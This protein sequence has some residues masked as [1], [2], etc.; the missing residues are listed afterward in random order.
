[1]LII[2]I[3]V[4]WPISCL[5]LLSQQKE[6]ELHLYSQGGVL[7][8]WLSKEVLS[9][10]NCN[11]FEFPLL[12]RCLHHA[13]IQV[14]KMHQLLL[15]GTTLWCWEVWMVC[16]P[17]FHRQSTENQAK[18]WKP[19]PEWRDHLQVHQRQYWIFEFEVISC[20]IIPNFPQWQARVLLLNF[21]EFVLVIFF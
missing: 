10:M 18:D 11:S 20:I 21:W 7:C 19:K 16:S 5:R 13:T 17:K 2:K 3:I 12:F 15:L 4:F 6:K 1:M 14:G 9:N 8:K